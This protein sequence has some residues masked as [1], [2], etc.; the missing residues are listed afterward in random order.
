MRL[1][2]GPHGKTPSPLPVLA[3][4]PLP[5]SCLAMVAS[6][7]GGG[8]GRGPGLGEQGEAWSQHKYLG[9]GSEEETEQSHAPPADLPAPQPGLL[10]AGLVTTNKDR[11][12]LVLNHRDAAVAAGESGCSERAWAGSPGA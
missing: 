5:L 7:L 1:S 6:S 12:S 2:G 8:V 11:G 9:F 4:Q 10:G 3:C